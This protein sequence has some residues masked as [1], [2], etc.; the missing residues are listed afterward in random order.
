MAGLVPGEGVPEEEAHEQMRWIEAL[1]TQ[2][3]PCGCLIAD[4]LIN[5]CLIADCLRTRQEMQPFWS[6]AV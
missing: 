6:K 2:V 4:C 3:L 5:D 1:L